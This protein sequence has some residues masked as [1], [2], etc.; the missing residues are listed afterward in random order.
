MVKVTL[1]SYRFRYATNCPLNIEYNATY[2]FVGGHPNTIGHESTV[3][4]FTRIDSR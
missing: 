3:N 4:R 1:T 2:A